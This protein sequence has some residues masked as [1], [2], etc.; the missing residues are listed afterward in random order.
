MWGDFPISKTGRFNHNR[1]KKSLSLTKS[2]KCPFMQKELWTESD[3][4]F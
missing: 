1:R 4:N 2:Q 3:R